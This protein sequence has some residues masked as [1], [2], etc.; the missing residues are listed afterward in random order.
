M[1]SRDAAVLLRATQITCAMLK[2]KKKMVRPAK[3]KPARGIGVNAE[4]EWG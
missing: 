1:N 3:G 2:P 4:D